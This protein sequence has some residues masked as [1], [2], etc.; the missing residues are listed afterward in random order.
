VLTTIDPIQL[1]EYSIVL[2]AAALPLTY[3]PV[4]LVANDR[5]YMGDQANSRASNLVASV[6]LVLL[7]VVSV[8]TIPLLIVTKAGG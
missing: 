4:L 1:T 5:D 3:L 8:A 2:A 6:Y 7:L